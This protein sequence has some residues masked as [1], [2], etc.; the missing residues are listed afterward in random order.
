[1]AARSKIPVVRE[2]ITRRLASS[3]T[4]KTEVKE[5]NN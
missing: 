4:K 1:M 2:F 3:P 5:E